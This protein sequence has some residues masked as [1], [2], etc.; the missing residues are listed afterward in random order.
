VNARGFGF[1]ALTE[2]PDIFIPYENLG[3]AL[4]G[5]EV[6]AV[7]FA[8][9]KKRRPAGKVLRVIER[10]ERAIVGIYRSAKG[11]GEVF[12]ED[13]RLPQKLAI[14]KEKL[15]KGLS[16]KLNSGHVVV[17]RLLE[18]TKREETPV[19]TVTQVL[20]GQDDTG[21]DVKVVAVS[22][23]LE[24]DFPENAQEEARK[25]SRPNMKQEAKFRAD[26]RDLEVVTVDPAEARDLDDGVSVR[27]LENGLFEVGVHIAD[28]SH[29]V[30]VGSA[31]DEAARQ[32][33]TSVYFVSEV[34][35]ML[36]ERLSSDLCSLQPGKD[37]LAYSVLLQVDSLGTVHDTQI[38]ESI[39]KNRH[40]FS[41]EE[42]QK[43]L[44]GKGHKN[45]G[46]L[47]VLELISRTLR[48]VRKNRGSIDFDISEQLISVDKDGVPRTVR[49]KE[50]L[51]AHRLVEE[52]M[53]LANSSIASYVAAQQQKGKLKQPFVYR[54]HEQ[55]KQEDV[56]SFLNVLA[57]VGIPYKMG[58]AVAPD[59]Y[60]NVLEIIQ[61]LEFKDFVEKIALQSMTR[62][63]YET[64]NK[65][66]FGL[67][68]DAYTHFTSPIRRY[69]DLT[70]HRLLKD[71]AASERSRQAGAGAGKQGGKQGSGKQGGGKT[72]GGQARLSASDLQ[73]VCTHCNERERRAESAEREYIRL[74]SME[75]LS[76]RVGNIY[77][78][79][80]SGV[81]SFG[82][83]VE[84]T[85][86]LIEGLV[87]LSNLADDYYEFDEENYRYV[88]K[89]HGA[90]YRLGDRV[91]VRVESVSV[92]QRKAE[93]QII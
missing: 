33:A 7:V 35:P 69:A 31:L 86:Y 2:E 42:A 55:P 73:Q 82:L 90:A 14:P 88:G 5:D 44:A 80:I 43:V 38:T 19:G 56:E 85:R 46:T 26:L 78:G 87:P 70:V 6:E 9:S 64:A 61:N 81:T 62:A 91:D 23:G 40:R 93:L 27:Q 21:M 28:V 25:L 20:G 48:Q 24:L 77:E 37:R 89:K 47:H 8:S 36:P 22:K 59:D 76:R 50:R 17:A 51:E 30:P 11:G 84:L 57:N 63:Q 83:F 60:R 29:F 74:K 10:A 65:G 3:T 49:P 39:I 45:A 15:D 67:A 71:I 16:R 66:H 58:E 34:L 13:D 68:F 12:P 52:L 4:D 54:N 79:V 75:F 72:Q 1:V 92:E 41:Y 53:L 18:W 32:R